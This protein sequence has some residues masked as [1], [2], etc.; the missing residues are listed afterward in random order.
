MRLLLIAS[1][2]ALGAAA[3]T[4]NEAGGALGGAALGGAAGAIIGNNTG[5]GDAA[6]GAAVGAVVGAA[7]G[8]YAGCVRD[9]GCGA[10]D[11]RRERRDERFAREH[12]L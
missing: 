9:G 3:C 8:A 1:V 12:L 2:A 4:Q 7:A 5:S 10:N 11:N 6:S